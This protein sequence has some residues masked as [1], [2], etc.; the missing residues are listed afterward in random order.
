MT[1]GNEC[2]NC[3][4]HS[5]SGCSCGMSPTLH[6]RLL[7]NGNHARRGLST[8]TG[9]AACDFALEDMDH[10]LRKGPQ[11]GIVWQVLSG[12]GLKCV[13]NEADLKTWI[14]SN[15]KARGETR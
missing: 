2:G 12:Q 15:T 5:E 3:E 7:T 14:I 9:C 11:A 1:R 4:C 10:I 6:D 13:A 8:N